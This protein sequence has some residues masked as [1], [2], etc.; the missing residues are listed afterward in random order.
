MRTTRLLLPVVTL[1]VLLTGCSGDDPAPER[2]DTPAGPTKTE[3]TEP[4]EEPAEEPVDDAAPSGDLAACIIGEW[5]ADLAQVVAMG[6][7]MMAEMGMPATTTARG[8]TLTTVDATTITTAYTD[9]VTEMTLDVEGQTIVST[10]R[11]DGTM[12]QSYTLVGDVLTSVA[13]GDLSG[14]AIESTVAI[15]GVEV[16]GY[17]EGFQQGLSGASTAGQSG[18]QQVSCSGDTLTMT[19]V[20]LEDLLGMPDMTVTYRRH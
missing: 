20:G 16:P 3:R 2:D 8:E 4:A 6:D 5:S 11:M 17:S 18:T 12:T 9:Y 7:A 13:A 19:T 1:A 15:D 10:T 14:I